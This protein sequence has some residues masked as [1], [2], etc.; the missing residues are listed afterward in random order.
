[1]FSKYKY[2][3]NKGECIYGKNCNYFHRL[4]D[5]YSK[6]DEEGDNKKSIE[7]LENPK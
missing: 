2:W 6:E 4:Y 7:K 5:P 3:I 1:L